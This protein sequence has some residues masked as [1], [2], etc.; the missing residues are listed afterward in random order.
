M[1]V[2]IDLCIYAPIDLR[3]T[4]H[5][6]VYVCNTCAMHVSKSKFN[7]NHYM[8]MCIYMYAWSCAGRHVFMHKGTL[9]YKYTY[10]HI[11]II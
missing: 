6:H 4:I 10:M 8:S 3:M 2:S 1:S 5:F 7:S 11:Y 9:K